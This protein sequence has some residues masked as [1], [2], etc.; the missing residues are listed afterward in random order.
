MKPL[1]VPNHISSSRLRSRSSGLQDA[2]SRTLQQTVEGPQPQ[3][4]SA[5]P[6]GCR[7]GLPA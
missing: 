6:A 7:L 5:A 2:P 3:A 1:R 4:A